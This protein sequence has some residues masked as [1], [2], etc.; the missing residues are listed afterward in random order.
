MPLLEFTLP[1][2]MEGVQ[3]RFEE[4][5]TYDWIILTSQNGV[6]FSLSF[7]ETRL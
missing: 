7:L 1:D 5:L 2:H 3:Q 6:D 4:L